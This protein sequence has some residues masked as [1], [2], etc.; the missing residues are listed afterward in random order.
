LE[1]ILNEKK[2]WKAGGAEPNGDELKISY[3][4]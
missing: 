1:N 2:T 4:T 3:A